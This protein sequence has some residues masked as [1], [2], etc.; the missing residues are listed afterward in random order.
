MLILWQMGHAASQQPDKHLFSPQTSCLPSCCTGR[1]H[2]CVT[3]RATAVEL[4]PALAAYY[5]VAQHELSCLWLCTFVGVCLYSSLQA[6]QLLSS[7]L[8]T[9]LCESA[10]CLSCRGGGRHACCLLV[11]LCSQ[12]QSAVQGCHS[13]STR[14]AQ[15]LC[16]SNAMRMQNSLLLF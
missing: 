14:A 15:L 9:G 11:C 3:F 6:S 7:S 4:G 5:C 12:S 13:G 1:W 8:S 16:S 10:A 2:T